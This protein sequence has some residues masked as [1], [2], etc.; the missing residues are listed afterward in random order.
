LF[1]YV[2][3]TFERRDFYHAELGWRL[4]EAARLPNG[5]LWDDLSAIL[6]RRVGALEEVL[7]SDT[8]ST[9]VPT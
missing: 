7:R 9:T 1:N 3:R 2:D 4:V 6:V 8:G 5:E